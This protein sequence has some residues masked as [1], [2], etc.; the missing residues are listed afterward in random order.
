MTLVLRI[1]VTGQGQRPV[2]MDLGQSDFEATSDVTN[3]D[4]E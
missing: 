4:A 2:Y 1:S 3:H